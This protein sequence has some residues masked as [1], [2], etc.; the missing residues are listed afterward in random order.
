MLNFFSRA[1]MQIN[2]KAD[3]LKLNGSVSNAIN[4]LNRANEMQSDALG[5]SIALALANWAIQKG[6]PEI[7]AIGKA[8]ELISG[9]MMEEVNAHSESAWSYAQQSVTE[10]MREFQLLTGL[11]KDAMLQLYKDYADGKVSD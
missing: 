11:S 4:D 2:D 8:T 6:G 7:A 9:P 1:A 3:T 10:A 5:Q